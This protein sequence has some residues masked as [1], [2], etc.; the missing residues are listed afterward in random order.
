MPRTMPVGKMMPKA[1]ICVRMWIHNIES[2]KGA[3]LGCWSG[4]GGIGGTDYG[5][6]GDGLAF[7]YFFHV[8]LVSRDEGGEG[9]ESGDAGEGGR[10]GHGRLKGWKHSRRGGGRVAW[11]DVGTTGQFFGAALPCCI[12]NSVPP[13]LCASGLC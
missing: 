10:G 5:P 11:I 3:W 4:G 2:W 6:C 12:G 7:R 8:M 9:E 13:K 1:R